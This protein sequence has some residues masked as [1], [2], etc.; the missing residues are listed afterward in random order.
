LA[1]A[2]DENTALISAPNIFVT[3]PGFT[4]ETFVPN[5]ISRVGMNIDIREMT[6]GLDVEYRLYGPGQAHYPDLT[7][8]VP[9]AQ[10]V[11]ARNWF[12]DASTGKGVNR[13]LTVEIRDADGTV[14]M[15]ARLLDCFPLSFESETGTLSVSVGRL[16]LD[17]VASF[18]SLPAKGDFGDTQMPVMPTHNVET[19]GGAGTAT[20]RAIQVSGGAIR[21][22]VITSTVGS[23]QFQTRAPGHKTV[24]AV[25]MRLVS[26]APDIASWINETAAGQPWKRNVG[27]TP[28]GGNETRLFFDAFPVRVTLINPLLLLQNGYA[29]AALDLTFK[30]IRLEIQ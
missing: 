24:D 4:T 15:K 2:G 20:S 3:V 25:S 7:L 22:E 17:Q 19:T 13:N 23:D 27:V 1:I 29:P 28:A 5:A 6:T 14:R 10:R 16:I 26:S 12:M 30:P 18:G 11:S 21:V 8:V 9:M